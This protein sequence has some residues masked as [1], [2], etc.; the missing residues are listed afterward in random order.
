MPASGYC[1]PMTI[2]SL[3]RGV[4]PCPPSSNFRWAWVGVENGTAVAVL[5]A[6]LRLEEER[7]DPPFPE[8][9]RVEFVYSMRS[10]WGAQLARHAS[11]ALSKS[12]GLTLYRS[13][14]ATA[15]GW[16]LL[17]RRVKMEI[18][19]LAIY[20]HS[21]YLDTLERWQDHASRQ[22]PRT[23]MPL[24]N[25]RSVRTTQ[26]RQTEGTRNPRHRRQLPIPPGTRADC[27]QCRRYDHR[28]S[29][30]VPSSVHD[31][32]SLEHQQCEHLTAA[33]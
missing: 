10:G 11:T 25:L 9:A 14:Y 12:H 16:N 33:A 30:N 29:M 32:P 5:T 27:K 4:A 1:P 7:T 26:E 17:A 6:A 13:G 21:H 15:A 8:C 31:D 3:S 2:E 22:P 28:P 20:Q 23:N 24:L 18:D 19:P